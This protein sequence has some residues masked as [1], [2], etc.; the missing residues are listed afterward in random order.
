MS[1]CTCCSG[2]TGIA[3]IDQFNNCYKTYFKGCCGTLAGCFSAIYIFLSGMLAS[4]FNC[5][6]SCC[7]FMGEFCSKFFEMI[8]QF[9]QIIADCLN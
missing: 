1:V 9:C 7:K 3:L 4:V 5:F 8:V 6:G 2:C